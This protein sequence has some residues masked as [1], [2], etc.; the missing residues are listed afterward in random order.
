MEL[1]N[2]RIETNDSYAYLKAKVVLKNEEQNVFFAVEKEYQ[3]ALDNLSYDAFLIGS[4]FNFMKEGGI[5]KIH[6]GISERLAFQIQH[7]F[8]KCLL[9]DIP[10]F[11]PI[12]IQADYFTK[13]EEYHPW[14]NL[15]GVSGGVDSFYTI[16]RKQNPEVSSNY[17]LNSLVYFLEGDPQFYNKE[18]SKDASEAI[19]HRLNLPLIKTWT[20]LLSFVETPFEGFC[21][22]F[23]LACVNSIKKEVKNYWTASGSTTKGFS[24]LYEDSSGYEPLICSHLT[25]ESLEVYSD[26]F[27]TN[28]LEK[29]KFIS[30]FSIPREHLDV[31][32]NRKHSHEKNCS[33]CDKCIRTLFQLEALGT[34]DSFH[35]VFDLP[36]FKKHRKKYW[37][38]LWYHCIRMG[39]P[40]YQEI[41]EYKKN[42]ESGYAYKTPYFWGAK[43]GW[44]NQIA[45]VRSFL[46]N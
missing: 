44:D 31:C 33:R 25:T 26:D 27:Y 42:N 22:Y 5:L 23:N 39:L 8:S 30:E 18:L 2:L 32:F 36:H 17:R 35:E 15:T 45:K 7:Y 21:T 37:G 19:S 1:K 3:D 20:N 13:K 4:L 38:Y 12:E 41:L 43:I 34:I 14:R 28:R 10:H 29:T 11:K 6:G 40:Y 16:F 9:N 24:V 46:K